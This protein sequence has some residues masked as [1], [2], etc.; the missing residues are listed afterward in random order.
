MLSAEGAILVQF[1]LLS[2]VSLVLVG[3]V[4]ALLALRAPKRDLHTVT[5]FRHIAAPP[6]N[7]WPTQTKNA[8]I[9]PNTESSV[10]K[11]ARYVL[12]RYGESALVLP[13]Y[14]PVVGKGFLRSSRKNAHKKKA[15]FIGS[16]SLSQGIYNVKYFF[17]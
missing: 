11:R 5:G 4:V 15:L 2:G 8:G 13:P 12:K 6:S 7:L 17:I 3:I 14:D 9:G 16:G 1:Q 10:L